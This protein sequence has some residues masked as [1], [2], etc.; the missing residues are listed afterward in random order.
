MPCLSVGRRLWAGHKCEQ[1]YEPRLVGIAHR[2]FAFGRTHSGCCLQRSSWICCRRSAIVLVISIATPLCPFA[3]V[4]VV[5]C[6]DRTIGHPADL[7]IGRSPTLLSRS[8]E[9]WRCDRDARA[10]GRQTPLG[11][12]R[13]E[14][15]CFSPEQRW[16]RL[17]R[18]CSQRLRQLTD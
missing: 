13:S 9:R 2:R 11:K 1:I 8:G 10:R 17:I 18:R 14:S 16:K 12:A 3:W 4:N 6:K 15:A 7:C 5:G